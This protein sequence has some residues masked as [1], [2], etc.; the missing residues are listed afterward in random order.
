VVEVQ[1]DRNG[2]AE[3]FDHTVDHTDDGL[4]AAHVLAGTLRN[5]EDD[6]RVAFLC[7][8]QDRLGPFEVV[9]VELT[10]SVVAGL[11]LVEHF[12]CRN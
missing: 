2:D 6:R 1:S 4:V 12:L 11:C 8:E 5:T 10:D 7:G 3:F 9:D